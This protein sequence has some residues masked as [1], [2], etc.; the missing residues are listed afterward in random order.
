MAFDPNFSINGWFYTYHTQSGASNDP[1]RGDIVVSRYTANGSPLTSNSANVASA[2]TLLT[3]EHSSHTDHNGGWIGF[4]PNDSNRLYIATGDAGLSNDQSNNAQ[5]PNVL[6]GKM[7]RVDVSGPGDYTIPADNASGGLP[8][9]YMLGLRNPWRN[10]FDRQTSDFYIADVGERNWE[11][12]NFQAGGGTTAPSGGENYGWRAREGKHDNAAVDDLPP[13]GAI[14]PIYEYNHNV[15]GSITGGYVYRGS[16]V[17]GLQGDYIFG[18]YTDGRFWTGEVSGNSLI[19]IVERTSQLGPNGGGQTWAGRIASFGEGANGELYIVGL[20]GA[21]YRII[22]EPG[23]WALAALALVGLTL[24]LRRKRHTLPIM[25]RTT[26]IALALAS[27]LA[28]TNATSR[29][30]LTFDLRAVSGS[31][32]I[33]H[34]PKSVAVSHN[35]VGGWIDFELHALVTGDNAI[36]TDDGMQNFI[37]SMLSTHAGRGAVIGNMINAGEIAPRVGRGVISPFDGRA[38]QN[39]TIQNL[40][41]D[42]ELEIGGTS[43][44]AES[45]L[46]AA[47]TGT[48]SAWYRGTAEVADF[49]LYRFTLPIESVPAD[50]LADMTRVHF[51]I[52]FHPGAFLWAQDSLSYSA[53]TFAQRT[54]AM[55]VNEGV[56]IH[57]AQT[58]EELAAIP[59]PG[60]CL[61]ALLGAVSAGWFAKRRRF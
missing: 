42:P 47:R 18:D 49:P 44:L 22:P 12:V 2:Q 33:I 55:L 30:D 7:L 58:P 11:E 29:A 9:I 48:G 19:N 54:G 51:H 59:E 27:I 3:I 13:A 43:H 17:N 56:L 31:Q 52:P 60:T 4:R 57:T 26:V 36:S 45:G 35:S 61:L 14:D 25:N 8:E 5:N 28:L 1:N 40:D 34:G 41:D 24:G 21:V 38:H 37:G 50:S 6:L 16:K 10:S 46:I 32:I 39:G 15:G 23:T 53:S 20:N